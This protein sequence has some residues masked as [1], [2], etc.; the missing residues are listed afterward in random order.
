M[1]PEHFKLISI[2]DPV[3]CMLAVVFELQVAI[4]VAEVGEDRDGQKVIQSGVHSR[5][6]EDK[7]ELPNDQFP[8][9]NELF[10]QLGD[11]ASDQVE[12]KH[13]AE[14]LG[15]LG[16]KVAVSAADQVAV[17]AERV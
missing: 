8:P 11:H 5:T 9:K 13:S 15:A 10:Q 6:A 16:C 17:H 7:G 3:A 12:E 1:T 14:R 4:K 2:I